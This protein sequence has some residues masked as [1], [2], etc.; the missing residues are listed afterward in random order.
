[1]SK[2]IVNWQTNF[3]THASTYRVCKIDLFVLAISCLITI[4]NQTTK[5]IVSL[6]EI[7]LHLY[8][9]WV[10]NFAMILYEICCLLVLKRVIKMSG[11]YNC[12]ILWCHHDERTKSLRVLKEK[13]VRLVSVD[14][15]N[16]ATIC[17][18]T[19]F[20]LFFT[21]SKDFSLKNESNWS[22]AKLIPALL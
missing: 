5:I 17:W 22:F 10:C 6:F 11:Q 19:K 12:S 4:I 8:T 15:L 21:T 1:M 3:R 20:I 13:D 16:L 2:I 9:T 18:G 7:F 14:Q